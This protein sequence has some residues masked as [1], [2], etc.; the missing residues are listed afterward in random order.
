MKYFNPILIVSIFYVFSVTADQPDKFLTIS[1]IYNSA[2]FR[3]ESIHDIHWTKD[4]K[5][6]VYREST[7][8]GL[9]RDFIYYDILSGEKSVYISSSQIINEDTNKEF[10]PWNVIWSP[11]EKHLL[12]T[13]KLEARSTKSGGDFYLYNI[14]ENKLK[15][16]PNAGTHQLNAQFSPNGKQ[17]GFVR[18]NNLFLYDINSDDEIQLTYGG[19]E[20]VLNGH[21]DWVYEEEFKIIEGWCWS[22]DSRYIAFWQVDENDVPEFQIPLFDSLYPKPHKMRYPKAGQP[23]SKVRIGVINTSTKELNWFQFDD[24]EDFYIPRIQWLQNSKELA[25]I[26][27]NRL[28]NKLQIYLG[29]ISGNSTSKIYEEEEDCWIEI[30]DDWKFLSSTDHYIWTSEKSGFRHIYIND[31]SSGEEKQITRGNWEVREVHAVDESRQVIYFTSTQ[32]SPLENHL[33]CID[34]SGKNLEKLTKEPGWHRPQ[35]SPDFSYYIDRYSTITIPKKVKLYKSDGTE[36]KVLAENK[37]EVLHSYKISSPEFFE[38]KIDDRLKLNGWILKPP[39]FDSDKQ[40]PLL[41]YSYGGPGSQKVLNEWGKVSLWFHLLSQNGIIVACIDNR[42]TEGR[43]AEFKKVVYKK[44]GQIDVDDQIRAAK[45]LA[46]FD[47]IDKNRIGIYGWSYGGYMSAMC[48]LKGNDIFKLAV[49]VA[50]VSDWRFYDT[51]YTERYMQIPELNADGYEQGSV[52]NYVNQ[53][54]GKLLLIHG[55]ADDNVHLQNSIELSRALIIQNKQFESMFYP[56]R[57]HSIRRGSSNTREHLY[58]LITRFIFEN[59]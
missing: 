50:P 57:K 44:L 39:D 58:R 11:D 52:M 27:L 22:P 32:Q 33:Y 48:L 8:F 15:E 40:Y 46:D 9:N 54:N 51:I 25:I 16:L 1:E 36:L 35:F 53:L 43:G 55:M 5:G 14:Q 37:M 4:G 19:A 47:Y 7:K 34:F 24:S 21:F 6:I 31:I 59:L 41:I 28:Q 2:T 29:N 3:E 49:S 23:N 38:V 18:D 13:A 42:G 12:F 20:H 30:K 17:V 10:V 45:Y 56:D 26:K